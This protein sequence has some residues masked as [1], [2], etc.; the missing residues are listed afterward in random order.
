[1]SVPT[2][3]LMEDV[4]EMS[5]TVSFCG[6]ASRPF[7]AKQ[8][9]HNTHGFEMKSPWSPDVPEDSTIITQWASHR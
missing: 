7:E 4:R 9:A 8:K 6:H 1:M 5:F 2:A 3:R